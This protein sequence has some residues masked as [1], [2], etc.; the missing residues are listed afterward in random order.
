MMKQ[1]LADLVQVAPRFVRSVH[2]ENDA[3]TSGALDGYVVSP[4]A[5]DVVMRIVDSLR[6]GAASRAWALV[7]PYGSGKSSFATFLASMLDQSESTEAGTARALFTEYCADKVE[8]LER[9]LAKLPGPYMV[10]PVTAERLPLGVLV[11]RGLL[12]SAR[13]YWGAVAG[14]TP[15]LL[16]EIEGVLQRGLKGDGPSDHDVIRLTRDLVRTVARSKTRAQGVCLIIDEFGKALEWA[17]LH[18]TTSDIYLLQQLAELASRESAGQLALIIVLHQGLEAY[19]ARL[20][21][22]ARREWLKV[23]GR[24]EQIPYLEARNHLVRLVACA[25]RRDSRIEAQDLYARAKVTASKFAKLMQ[26][27]DAGLADELLSCFPLNPAA[28]SCLG[29]VFRLRLGQNERSLFAFLASS[30][31]QGFQQFLSQETDRASRTF[32][33]DDL[34]DYLV[35]NTGVRFAIDGGDR[36]WSAAELALLRL[37]GD[38]SALDAR[39]IKAVAIL[40]LIERFVG[41]KANPDTLALALE[42]ERHQIES[43]LDRLSGSSIVVYRAYKAAYQLWDGSDLD[44]AGRIGRWREQVKAEG[45]LGQRL[46]KYLPARPVVATRHGYQTGT[47][48]YL[49]ARF[50]DASDVPR[51]LP[52]AEEGDGTL[53][54][55]LA[56][57]DSELASARRRLAGLKRKPTERPWVFAFPASDD[58]LL[59]AVVEVFAVEETLRQTPELDGD[60]VAR[61][62]LGERRLAAESAL[63]AALVEAF[64]AVGRGGA[65]RWACPGHKIDEKARASSVASS[66][67]DRVYE[68]A[69]LV[70]NELINRG[71]LSTAAARA[72][73]NLLERMIANEARP[74]LGIEGSPPELSMYLSLL[75]KMGLHIEFEDGTWGFVSPTSRRDEPGHPQAR[76]SVVW[77]RIHTLLEDAPEGRLTARDIVARLEE[78][79]LGIR[80]GVGFVL[81]MAYYLTE[82]G[83]VL[84]YEENSFVPRVQPEMAYRMLRQPQ[85]IEFQRLSARSSLGLMVGALGGV[86]LPHRAHPVEFLRIVRHVV[87]LVRALSPYASTTRDVSERT[88]QIRNAI[89]AARDPLLLMTASIPAA[90]GIDVSDGAT[91]DAEGAAAYASGLDQALRELA[92]ADQALL[93]RITDTL[94]VLLREREAGPNF[95]RRM[96]FRASV[97]HK[98]EPPLDM[99]PAVRRFVTVSVELEPDDEETHRIWLQAV[100]TAVLGRPPTQWSDQDVALF[101]LQAQTVCDQ[102]RATEALTLAL[103]QHRTDGLHAYRVSVLDGDGTERTGVSVLTDR[104]SERVQRFKAKVQALAAELGIYGD[105]MAYAVIASMLEGAVQSA[106]A[107]VEEAT[108]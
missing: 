72:Q 54:Y 15:E 79:P 26:E 68:E 76:L 105:D 19:A 92:G 11:L 13:Q 102:F 42:V 6:L 70:R 96:A 80:R 98:A 58:A 93:L 90:L 73:R 10:A 32:C 16:D 39:V 57:D 56:A 50:V 91:L 59:D 1:T 77:Q 40:A 103:G 49:T 55:V 3:G 104:E 37:P 101:G 65:R 64:G 33:L 83:K 28:A 94:R 88:H 86:L 29:L 23:E 4:L 18:P 99:T 27:D 60:P 21:S 69:P 62:E 84:L 71:D 38:A 20:P 2:L 108:P 51:R 35:T 66:I 47:L 5:R 45:G 25:I 48:R 100:G 81:L 85:T 30:E 74:R 17:A 106:Q 95:Y 43:A 67:F 36:I 41:P 8:D 14:R 87:R 97:L 7:G 75:L 53:F 82:S 46:Q 63:Q 22:E 24:F 78:P 61:R 89:K 107:T 44:I 34:Y 12:K 31:P 9:S 52:I